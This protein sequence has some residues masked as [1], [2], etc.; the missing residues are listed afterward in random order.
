MA[1]SYPNDLRYDDRRNRDILM[2]LM[3]ALSRRGCYSKKQLEK[4][5]QRGL[6]GQGHGF[7]PSKFVACSLFYL[8]VQAAA[9]PDASFFLTFDGGKRRAINP[10]V[11]IDK[12]IID[13]RPEPE[14]ELKP[15]QPV[16]RPMPLT[17]CPRLN[18]M[19][20]L[21]AEEEAAK[22]ETYRARRQAEAIDRWRNATIKG[23][24]DAFLRLAHDLNR[25]GMSYGD[26]DA[27][28]RQEAGY[29][30]HPS[31]RRDQIKYIMRSLRGSPCRMAA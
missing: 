4:R 5:A 29:G 20:E 18:R 30:R 21:I 16:R 25:M 27:T 14:P 1:S 8:P 3:K 23:G 22:A 2:Q 19:R 24:N 12:T 13:H 9:G 17:E 15:T 6:G 11:W 31:E 7:D 26:I 10:Y 28:L